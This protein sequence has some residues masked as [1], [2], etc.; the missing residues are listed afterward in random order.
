MRAAVPIPVH[1]AA[2]SLS[3]YANKNVPNIPVRMITNAIYWLRLS[4][5][6]SSSNALRLNSRTLAESSS[7][8]LKILSGISSMT[9][10][11]LA[12]SSGDGIGL[13]VAECSSSIIWFSLPSLWFWMAIP[14]VL[15]YLLILFHHLVGRLSKAC[16][17]HL[18]SF[19]G[20]WR[21]IR[22]DMPVIVALFSNAEGCNSMKNF[23]S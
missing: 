17:Q 22:M 4:N 20:A 23:F 11:Y 21:N 3:Q 16:P 5:A 12:N 19:V 10:L 6:A 1:I 9:C 8:C 13:T 14:L 15:L 18:P 2:I 7:N